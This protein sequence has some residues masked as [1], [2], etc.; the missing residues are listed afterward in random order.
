VLVSGAAQRGQTKRGKTT[1]TSWPK[2]V[3][4]N[5]MTSGDSDETM[6]TKVGQI[7]VVVVFVCAERR[8]GEEGEE[9]CFLQ[10]SKPLSTVSTSFY[11]K[12]VRAPSM[13]RRAPGSFWGS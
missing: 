4:S 12:N 5:K 8:T 1:W 10:N 13:T 11:S 7:V 9:R 2:P 3:E 6:M